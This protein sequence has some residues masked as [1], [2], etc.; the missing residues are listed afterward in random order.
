MFK[1]KKYTPVRVFAA[2]TFFIMIAVNALAN[3]LPINDQTTGGVSESYPNL[4]APA[5]YTF[6]IWGVIYILLFAYTIY[7]F[8]I[9]RGRSNISNADLLDKIGIFFI[10]SSIAN[11][12][13][14]FAW[15]Y[16]VIWLSLLLM[17]VILISLI[18]IDREIPNTGLTFSERILVKIPFGIY[19]GWI[20]VATIANITTF[21]VSIGW[22]GFGLQES[23]WTVIVLVIGF[24]IVTANML[25]SKNIAYG[26]TIIWAYTGILIKHIS[27]SGFNGDYPEIISG[28][29]ICIALTVIVLIVSLFKDNKERNYL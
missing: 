1:E 28:A 22:R 13:W 26:L 11:S 16:N 18:I 15:H 25:R 4:F 29:S 6:S 24:L 7:Q 21:L 2:I 27:P 20:T 3:I 9:F 5:G 12:I 19:F 8:G 23:A 14:I 17:I 10:V